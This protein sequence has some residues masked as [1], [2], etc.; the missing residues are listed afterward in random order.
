MKKILGLVLYAA[1]MFGVTAGLGM[2]L[3]KTAPNRSDHAENS[4]NHGDAGFGVPG[5][6]SGGS[7]KSDVR[8]VHASSSHGGGHTAS[9]GLHKQTDEQLPVAVRSSP[10]S[11]EEIVRMGMSLNVRDEALRQR[12]QTMKDADSQH[13][14][15]QTDVEGA[16]QQVEYLLAQASDQ[17]AA[18]EELVARINAQ[19]DAVNNERLALTN[20]KQQLKADRDTLDADRRQ[21]E[22]QKTALTQSEADLNLKRKQL[23]TDRLLLDNDRTKFAVDGEKLIKDREKWVSEVVRLNDEKQILA[24]E[25]GQIDVE[26]KTLDQ[27]KRL[28][29]SM[30]GAAA[31]PSQKKAPDAAASKQNL[32]QLTEMFEGMTPLVAAN[33]IKELVTTG[34]ID[35]VVDVL[36]QL[37]QRKASAIL[38]SI[39]DEKLVSE[40]LIKINSRNSQTKAARN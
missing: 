39:S 8:T 38:D 14:L 21:M 2:L 13:R 16:Q 34:E 17:R 25:R 7:A 26:R 6:I 35:M 15:I 12:E 5:H 29:S 1:V 28:L 9:S 4:D 11:I 3:K 19:K 37:E 30:P 10:M 32:K 40:F 22:A 20:E 24:T 23:D 33:T 27:D 31:L 18:I 36:A